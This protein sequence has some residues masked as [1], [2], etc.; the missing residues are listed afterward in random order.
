[1]TWNPKF[2]KDLKF[3]EAG[4]NWLVWLG[5]DNAKVEVKTERDIWAKTGNIV[6]E[7]SCRGKPSGIAKTEADWWVH[8][9][10][11]DGKVVHGFM[12]SVPVL[13]HFLRDIHRDPSMFNC[14]VLNGGD[15]HASTMIV[16]PIKQLYLV[17]PLMPSADS[18][19]ETPS[20]SASV[21]S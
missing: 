13:K 17:N 21:R 3:G 16:V 10:S 8:L 12:W 5:S 2:D 9:L 7:Y 11:K 14:K 18:V 20:A 19:K 1:M 4:E 6:F 15:D